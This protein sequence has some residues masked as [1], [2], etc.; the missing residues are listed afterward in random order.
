MGTSIQFLITGA[1]GGLGSAII[2]TL[3]QHV[4]AAS[5]AASSSN[6]AAAEILQHKFPGTQFRLV[7]YDDISSLEAAFAGVE[8]LFF[9]SSNTF[10][11]EK[12]NGQHSNVIKAAKRAGVGHTYYSSLAFGGLK[13]DSQIDVQQAHLTTESSLADSNILYTSIREGCYADSFPLK[14]TWYPTSTK[15]YLPL[16]D[17]PV[18]Y[19]SRTELGEATANLML[20]STPTSFANNIALLTGPAAYTVGQ[21]ADAVAEASSRDLE[22]ERVATKEEYVRAMVEYDKGEG[23]GGK[24]E[25]FF[26]KWWTLHEGLAKGEGATVHPLMEEL[27]GRRPRDGRE[28]VMELVREGE[29]NGK[30]YTWHQNYA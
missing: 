24:S 7:D 23:R 16:P 8:K 21:I 1:T 18:A 15:I 30:G 9:V 14:L 28:F 29:K 10:D 5:V 11:T 6:P 25:G 3:L 26:G 17:G 4:P 22:V 12:R 13:S 20:R 27:L 19:A 2:T